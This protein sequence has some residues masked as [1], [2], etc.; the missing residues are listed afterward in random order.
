ME[1]ATIGI[2]NC[3]LPI[4]RPTRFCALGI[5][6]RRWKVDRLIIRTTVDAI[7]IRVHIA[8]GFNLF[9]IHCFLRPRIIVVRDGF[10]IDISADDPQMIINNDGNVWIHLMD[11]R[12]HIIDP[13]RI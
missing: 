3:A 10:C 1:V 5:A 11:G 4:T 13:V 7:D 2:G 6:P 8:A 9:Q 12:Y